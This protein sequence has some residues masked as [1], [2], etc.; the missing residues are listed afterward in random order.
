ML[1]DL[2]KDRSRIHTRDLRFSTYPVNDTD[3]VVHGELKDMRHVSIFHVTGVVKHPGPI[4]HI[5][6]TCRLSPDPLRIVEAE[7]EMP[8]VPLGECRECLDRVAL[9]KGIEIKSGFSGEVDRIMGRTKGCTHLCH[10]IKTMAQEM[11]HGWMTWNR[12]KTEDRPERPPLAKERKYLIDSCRVWK[13]G[14]TRIRQ[15]EAAGRKI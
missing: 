1:K 10:L 7:A 11:V 4:H 9:L 13:R 2:I 12:R 3:V 6:F 5:S 15:L 8:T 14:G